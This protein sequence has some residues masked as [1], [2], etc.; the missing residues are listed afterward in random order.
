VKITVQLEPITGSPPEVDYRWDADTDILSAKLRAGA[1]REGLSSSVE[2]EGKDGSWLVLDLMGGRV[3]GVEIAVW[4][5]V[6][7]IPSLAPPRELSDAHLLI[8]AGVRTA[9]PEALEVQTRVVAES[10]PARRTIHFRLGPLRSSRTVR[11][12][13]DLLVDIDTEA[14]LAGLWLL[15]VPPCP[16]S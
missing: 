14:R 3:D 15:N 11:V 12:A 16:P 5:D 10:D 4:P 1:V 7:L 2:L 13:R 6:R 8:P 9:E